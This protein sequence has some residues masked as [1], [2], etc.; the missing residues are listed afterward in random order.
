[1]T[2]RERLQLLVDGFGEEQAVRALE[3]LNPLIGA[4]GRPGQQ[5]RR[6]PDFVGIG[7]TGRTDI[8]ENVDHVLA[9][10]FGE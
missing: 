4:D 6:L 8:S 10:G 3:L 2:A 9:G 7:D 1:M 5:V